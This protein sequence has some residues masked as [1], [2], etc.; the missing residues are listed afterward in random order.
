MTRVAR[1]LKAIVAFALVVVVISSPLST[2]SLRGGQ[3][4]AAAPR[5]VPLATLLP[6]I[7]DQAVAGI[8]VRPR[9][10]FAS[11]FVRRLPVEVVVADLQE[12]L[13]V[14]CRRIE[15]AIGF[16][17]RGATQ[18]VSL[19]LIVRFSEAFDWQELPETILGQ[20]DFGQ[21]DG[22][23]YRKGKGPLDFSLMLLDER[24]LLLA[25]DDTLQR[26]LATR[27]TAPNDKLISEQ[28]SQ[29]LGKSL[30]LHVV[31]NAHAIQPLVALLLEQSRGGSETFQAFRALL[32]E[33]DRF[34]LRARLSSRPSAGFVL[35]NLADDGAQRMQV[36]WNDFCRA[37]RADQPDRFDGVTEL[38]EHDEHTEPLVLRDDRTSRQMRQMAQYVQRSLCQDLDENPL[39]AHRHHLQWQMRTDEKDL[40][41]TCAAVAMLLEPSLQ[42]LSATLDRWRSIDEMQRLSD[43][44]LAYARRYDHFPARANFSPDAQPLLS[45]R[46]HLLP[47][48]GHQVLYDQF[49]LDE[50][51]DSPHNRTL[52]AR[53]PAVYQNPRRGLDFRT[54]YAVPV[55]PGTMF[56]GS[57]GLPRQDVHDGPANTLMLVEADDEHAIIW[58]RPDD[59][60]YD[61]Q[62]PW[63][64]LGTWRESGFL[65]AQADGSLRFYRR[66]LIPNELRA[67]F[68]HNGGETQLH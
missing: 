67:F 58:T 50:P 68:S 63:N 53:M 27:A 46:V 60:P 15:L 61:Q 49:H 34:E 54:T 64:G 20:T 23:P 45:W 41:A 17:D 11:E 2:A 59:L 66:T 40:T 57:T 36:P 51:W 26:M 39:R 30:D 4:P 18:P 37:L 62:N 65:G 6:L 38:A 21:L 29:A 1:G 33:T 55:G 10:F 47:F 42:T 43:A 25:P 52:I 35:H 32:D 28:L 14:D 3:L 9:Q 12:R 24:T 48:L 8:V 5:V 31:V 7:T 16:L 13:G 19:G 56:E 22:R 44:M